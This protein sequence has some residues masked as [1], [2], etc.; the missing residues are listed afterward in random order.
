MAQNC[1]NYSPRT[2]NT[3]HKKIIKTIGHSGT[4]YFKLTR[5]DTMYLN[6]TPT[7]TTK[8]TARTLNVTATFAP[9][10]GNSKD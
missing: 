2:Q 10:I 4:V 6:P 3:A 8:E 5:L 9:K 1:F 7:G